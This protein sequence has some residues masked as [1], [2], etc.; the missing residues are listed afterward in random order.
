[1]YSTRPVFF[2]TITPMNNRDTFKKALLLGATEEGFHCGGSRTIENLSSSRLLGYVLV[3]ANDDLFYDEDVSFFNF[4]SREH[5]HLTKKVQTEVL[6]NHK[7]SIVQFDLG[8]EELELAAQRLESWVKTKTP[9]EAEFYVQKNHYALAFCEVF[10]GDL[11]MDIKEPLLASSGKIEFKLALLKHLDRNDEKLWGYFCNEK[12]QEAMERICDSERFKYLDCS[13]LIFI[14]LLKNKL[15]IANSR[16]LM[17]RLNILKNYKGV[18]TPKLVSFGLNKLI[19]T[20][21]PIFN[22]ETIAS[23]T[24]D[25]FFFKLIHEEEQFW[26]SKNYVLERHRLN[27]K[28][29][30]KEK[31]I[32]EAL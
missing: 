9:E 25:N 8:W 28:L 17:K 21:N 13:D 14:Q 20:P 30:P 7:I 19:D 11:S 26:K 3:I 18:W 12:N 23:N 29:P 32:P 16:M 24:N 6:H 15:T 22:I 4:V 27:H 1:M 10:G 2:D 31:I 5:V